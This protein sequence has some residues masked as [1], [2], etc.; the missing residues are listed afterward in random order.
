MTSCT[1]D[2]EHSAEQRISTNA[3]PYHYVGSG[4]SNVYLVGVPY[5]VCSECQKQAADIPAL[6]LLL[7]D[8]ARV[9]VE[10]SSPLTGAQVKFLRK[11]LSKRSVDFA[12]MISITPQRLSVIESSDEHTLAAG[13]DKLVRV[14]YRAL[15]GD[16]RLRTA[17]DRQGEFERWITS[18]HCQGQSERIVATWLENHKWQVQTEAIAA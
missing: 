7:S 2:C 6:E 9:I 4:L 17:F 10:K 11:R 3:C 16:H 13:R 5:L 18:I 12:A 15:S 8:I 14:I 1:H